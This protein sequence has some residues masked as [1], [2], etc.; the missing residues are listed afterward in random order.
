MMLATIVA[1]KVDAADVF[2]LIAVI[3]FA[4]VAVIRAVARSVDGVLFAAGA[5]F[6]FLGLLV[7]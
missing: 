5:A 4:V 1:G 6:G 7:L 2:F 3:L